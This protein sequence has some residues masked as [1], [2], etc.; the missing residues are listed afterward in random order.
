MKDS[1]SYTAGVGKDA[2]LGGNSKGSF[3]SGFDVTTKN[4]NLD[5]WDDDYERVDDGGTNSVGDRYAFRKT[6][7]CG[8]PDGNER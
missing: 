2:A 3:Q 8:R 7:A 5:P 6:G 1:I 4:D